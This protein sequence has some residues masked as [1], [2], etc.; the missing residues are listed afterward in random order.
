MGAEIED[1]GGTVA[2]GDMTTTWDNTPPGWDSFSALRGDRWINTFSSLGT[3]YSF[4]STTTK[5]DGLPIDCRWQSHALRSGDRMR[6]LHLK[7]VWMDYEADANSAASVYVGSSY[8]G[9]DY[10]SGTALSITTSGSPSFVPVWHTSNAPVFE[11]RL[12]D[13]GTPRIAAF[14]AVTID[15]GRF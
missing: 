5:D 14:Q 3:T 2:W 13:G 10:D 7:E 15:S 8:S 4:R 6:K 9:H 12:N 1:P 11:L